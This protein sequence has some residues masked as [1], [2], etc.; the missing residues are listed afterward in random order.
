[1]M[2]HSITD[3]GTSVLDTAPMIHRDQKQEVVQHKAV[4]R[5]PLL[6]A[7]RPVF[8][9]PIALTELVGSLQTVLTDPT[10]SVEKHTLVP[11]LLQYVGD[12]T[13]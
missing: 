12:A 4:P 6:P 8:D 13:F 3:I 1:M 9:R 7:V 11:K 5:P 2:I 10:M